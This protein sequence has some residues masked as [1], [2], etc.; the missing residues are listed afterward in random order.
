MCIS[1][2]SNEKEK[3]H[4]GHFGPSNKFDHTIMRSMVVVTAVGPRQGWLP[5]LF[6]PPNSIAECDL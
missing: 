2:T 4:M 1:C 3:M 5:F 6:M